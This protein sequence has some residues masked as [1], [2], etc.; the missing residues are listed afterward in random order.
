MEILYTLPSVFHP[1]LSLSSQSLCS[2][3][4]GLPPFATVF[5]ELR[6]IQDNSSSQQ[7][8]CQET[9]KSCI[10]LYHPGQSLL[11]KLKATKGNQLQ[12]SRAHS[13]FSDSLETYRLIDYQLYKTIEK[14]EKE[15]N[16]N[17]NS[18]LS[19]QYK[20]RPQADVSLMELSVM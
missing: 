12:V 7:P 2:S 10:S 9:V 15:N 20:I 13:L 8:P 16:T 11:A 14:M 17:S 6:A 19:F 5:L 3:Q 1:L 4:N 18:L